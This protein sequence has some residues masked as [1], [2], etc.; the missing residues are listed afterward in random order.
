MLAGAASDTGSDVQDPVAEG[1]D[2]GASQAG[3]CAE[4]DQSGPGDQIG[5]GQHDFQPGGVGPERVARQVTQ[6]GG[7]EFA[8]AVLDAGVLAVPQFQTGDLTSNDTGFGVG[9]E[10]GDPH[11]VGVGEPQLRT[12]MRAFFAQDQPGAGRPATEVDQVGGLGDPGPL[13]DPA[14]G[15]DRWI[16][17]IGE[18]EG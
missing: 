12:G 11:P 15:V 5:G 4:A 14:V 10:R 18:V 17:A 13:A 1:G 16:P 7:F 2:L 3:M 9:D 8:D 6:A